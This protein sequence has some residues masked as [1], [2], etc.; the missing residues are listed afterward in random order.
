MGEPRFPEAVRARLAPAREVLIET[1]RGGGRAV[2]RTIIW[3]VVDTAGR[4]LIRSWLGPGARWFREATANPRGAV[5]IG[6]DDR[7]PVR[8]QAAT[9]ADRVAALD[10]GY[11]AKYRGR[12]LEA[13]LDPELAATT[14]ELLP[15]EAG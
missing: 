15:D 6:D 4:V 9:D 5:W 11:R 14:L 1:S 8:F 13:M 7:I 3:V 12:S 10:A 2:H